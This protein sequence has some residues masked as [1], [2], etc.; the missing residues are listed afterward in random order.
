MDLR[1]EAVS[2]TYPGRPG[3]PPPAL[4][5]DRFRLV[6]QIAAKKTQSDER[7]AEHERPFHHPVE[8]AVFGSGDRALLRRELPVDGPL[9]ELTV[10]VSGRPERVALD[11]TATLLERDL[12]DNAIAV[13]GP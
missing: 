13:A 3:A 11:P 8:I 1:I 6:L 12:D 5:E 4:G 2:V 7:G 10:E 9:A